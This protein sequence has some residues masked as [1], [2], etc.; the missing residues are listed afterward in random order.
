MFALNTQQPKQTINDRQPPP[1]RFAGC[2]YHERPLGGAW[3]LVFVQSAQLPV[4]R[5]RWC[6]IQA[7]KINALWYRVYEEQV[8]SSVLHALWVICQFIQPFFMLTPVTTSSS[9]RR[10]PT[11]P[12]MWWSCSS[13]ISAGM[14][15]LNVS[16][17]LCLNR[18]HCHCPFSFFSYSPWPSSG[19]ESQSLQ[20]LLAP[21]SVPSLSSGLF[22]SGCWI[23]NSF[24][25]ASWKQRYWAT[26]PPLFSP[27]LSQRPRILWKTRNSRSLT[28]HTTLR[29]QASI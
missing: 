14:N 28:L 4:R 6:Y 26:P 15:C 7:S 1:A 3:D 19:A 25:E 10:S 24:R 8:K 13:W 22:F 29:G 17:A 5:L 20:P 18:L 9:W 2:S 23:P 16:H 27:A 21:H 12:I 11:P